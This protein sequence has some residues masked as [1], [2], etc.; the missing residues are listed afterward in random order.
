MT[1]RRLLA[2]DD[3]PDFMEILREVAE[4]LGFDVKTTEKADE[5]AEIYESFN[6]TVI[7]LD[8]VMPEVDGV[9]LA[10]WLAHEKCQAKIIFVTGHNPRF[11]DAA[12]DL[13]TKGDLVSVTT[14]SKPVSL[15]TLREALS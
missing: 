2:I 6:P 13:A 14:L 10:H 11:A 1:D 12:Q 4:G 5:F 15:G 7:V 8:L 3:E 9:E